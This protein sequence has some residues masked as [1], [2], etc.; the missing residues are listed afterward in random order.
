MNKFLLIIILILN[1][2]SWTKADDISDFQIEGMSVGDSLLNYMSETEIKKNK[3]NYSSIKDKTFS[4]VE[5]Q[6][7]KSETYDGFQL[8]YKTK[9]KKYIIFGVSGIVD[10]RNNYSICENQFNKIVNELSD[11]F[12]NSVTKSEKKIKKHPADKFGKSISTSILFE[13][14]NG[15]EVIVSMTDWSKEIGYLDHLR[16]VVSKKELSDW[17]AN[18]AYK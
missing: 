15:D 14:E 7:I 12:G 1:L 6:N 9:D 8:D 10:C 2:Q 18:K 3:Q 16:I 5:I 13:F 4:T 17:F 11:F